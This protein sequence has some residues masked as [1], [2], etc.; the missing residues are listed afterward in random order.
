MKGLASGICAHDDH[1]YLAHAI[2]SVREV[3]PVICY[4]SRLAW[5]GSAGEW[6]KTAEVAQAAGAE[7]VLGE[8][9]DE[10]LHRQ[11]ALAD[12]R[13][14]G[15]KFC[16]I[17]DGD[18]ILEPE[19][20]QNLVRLA[21]AGVAE[22]VYVHMDT[23]W[24]SPE[25]VIRP[26]EQL[27]PLIM[28]DLREVDHVYI[29]EYKGGRALTL[30]P[31]HGL[32]HHLSY[33][34]PDSRVQRKLD[35][36]GHRSE[37]LSDWY[38]RIW[39]G[40]DFDPRMRNLHPTHA[41]AYGWTERIHVPAILKDIPTPP[42]EEVSVPTAWPTV[43]IVIPLHGGEDDIR[44]CLE[45]LS[46]SRDLFHELIVVDDVSPDNAAIEAAAFEG[47]TLLSN[48]KNLGFGATCNRGLERATG[49]VVIFLNS[50][51]LV[52]RAGLI[53]L[54]ESLTS[55]GGIGATGPLT[56]NSGHGQIIDV[57]YTSRHNV[58][59]FAE[60]L[61]LSGGEDREVDMLVG[62]CI[63]AKRAVLREVGGFDE[64]F[65]IGQFEDNDLCYRM[66]RAGY[67]LLLVQSAFVHHEGSKSLNRRQ[68]HPAKLLTKNHKVFLDKWQED[69]ETGFASHLSGLGPEPIEFRPERKPEHLRKQMR[70]L[71]KRA[72]VSL[73]M[74]V[75]NEERV[76]ADCLKSAQGVFRQIVIVD[77]GS[78]DRTKEIATEFGAE[79]YDFPWTDS[80]SEA[81]NESLRHATGRWIFWM[82]A[83]D[84]L[85][86]TTAEAVLRSVVNAH[87]D[88][89]A[90]IV[91]VRF[92]DSGP[93]GGTQV[94]H[95][96]LFRNLKGLHF[97][98]HI[99]EQILPSLRKAGGAILRID[100]FVLH[101]GYDT[102]DEGQARKRDRDW[103]LLKLDLEDDPLNPFYNFNMGMTCHHCGMHEEAI[104]WLQKSIDYAAGEESHIRK[105]YA[106]MG[107][108]LRELGRLDEALEK[109]TEG[110]EAVNE[111]PELRFQSALVLSGLER[112]EE[113]IQQYLAINPDTSGFFSS[114]DIAILGC[115]RFHNLA[116][117]YES[118]GE[119]KEARAWYW[120]AVNEAG[121]IPSA[122]RL[123]EMSIELGHIR[124]AREAHTTL[125]N[126]TGPDERWVELGCRVHQEMGGDAEDFLRGTLEMRPYAVPLKMAM[127]RLLLNS[128]RESEALPHLRELDR[129]DCAEAVFYLGVIA[130]R[131]KDFL[132]ALEHMRRA[133]E[134]DPGY[135]ETVRQIEML[136]ELFREPDGDEP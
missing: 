49:E 134:L 102:S 48:E 65:G 18:E 79:V 135:E 16:L 57:T 41:W 107:I 22:R 24:K 130:N 10:S 95:V 60:D 46:S 32:M 54:V 51:T 27:T 75:K 40:W 53:R 82:D 38:N 69:L 6:E 88:V 80:F 25:Y 66:R 104:L 37:V 109:F 74:I 44:S 113:A 111:D 121:F 112:L 12:M 100:S 13:S 19:L 43:S 92:T 108:S 119:H 1:Y 71:A 77:T 93:S 29:R 73:C 116:S 15:F 59:L 110:L 114:I 33:A 50:D 128:G 94:D 131:N 133:H 123:V 99:H 129:L 7:V 4:V 76:L 26:R 55:G 30:T 34:G 45:S 62:F 58:D 61:A 91:P 97:R 87:P 106:M 85:P 47:V 42:R 5:N 52:P 8:W 83:D 9:A 117:L 3:G 125:L 67:K 103:K 126:L 115:K 132:R 36:W 78:T 81:R 72:D 127:A 11:T 28:L 23:Y 35:T 105:A 2:A 56:N 136:E 14:R 21:K 122:D 70:D 86:K 101:S 98:G 90:F 20:V 84:T 64:R 120:K 63:A 39:R 124:E 96:K 68:E 89:N 17:P 118:T 31:E